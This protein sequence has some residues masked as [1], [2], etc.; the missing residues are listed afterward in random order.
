MFV[1]FINVIFALTLM[2]LFR[3]NIDKEKYVDC[4]DSC[5][6]ITEQLIVGKGEIL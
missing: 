3:T 1:V 4:V 6:I 2:N 5:E